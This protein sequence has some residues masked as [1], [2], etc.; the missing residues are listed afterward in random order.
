LKLCMCIAVKCIAGAVEEQRALAFDAFIACNPFNSMHSMQEGAGA[1]ESGGAQGPDAA[2]E[3]AA[4]T[5]VPAATTTSASAPTAAGGVVYPPGY[6]PPHGG[7][8]VFYRAGGTV[9]PALMYGGYQQQ[10][11]GYQQQYGQPQYGQ[12]QYGQPQYGQPQQYVGTAHYGQNQHPQVRHSGVISD[13]GKGVCHPGASRPEPLSRRR[14][15]FFAGKCEIVDATLSGASFLAI[16][17]RSCRSDLPNLMPQQG[18]AAW[19]SIQCIQNTR[20]C[21]SSSTDPRPRLYTH[22]HTHT[23]TLTH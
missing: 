4:T 14:S 21:S 2:A 23:D 16:S 9:P 12:P 20:T 8:G 5:A 11:G 17:P 1:G 6:P 15:C 7:H 18:P 19:H 10:Y 22:T 3:P 13:R